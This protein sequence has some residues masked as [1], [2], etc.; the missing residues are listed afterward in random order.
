ME[1]CSYEVLWQ[2][3]EHLQADDGVAKASTLSCANISPGASALAAC[4]AALQ[5]LQQLPERP[6]AAQG[7]TA[8]AA[9]AGQLSGQPDGQLGGWALHQ[10]ASLWGVLKAAAQEAPAVPFQLML[11]V[12]NW[13]KLYFGGTFPPHV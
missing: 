7:E 8:A 3:T 6:L 2:A 5:V 11:E 1:R 9:A 4:M 12:S 13:F 10:A